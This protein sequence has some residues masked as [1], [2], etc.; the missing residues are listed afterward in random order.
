MAVLQMESSL[1]FNLVL[2]QL[3]TNYRMPNRLRTT[4]YLSLRWILVI[5]SYKE[6]LRERTSTTAPF[7]TTSVILESM[8]IPTY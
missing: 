5:M 8:T 6:G 2:L 7:E 1:Q 3:L 4:T